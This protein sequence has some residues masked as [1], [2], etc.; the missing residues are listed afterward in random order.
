MTDTKFTIGPLKAVP[1]Y[2]HNPEPIYVGVQ[3]VDG[4]YR[5][6]TAYVCAA[7][8]IDGVTREELFANANLYAAAPELYEALNDLSGRC[9]GTGDNGDLDGIIDA[10]CAALAKA[11]GES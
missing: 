1:A 9:M 6:S 5:G 4:T 8:H 11:R 7:E 10:A 3:Q 2:G